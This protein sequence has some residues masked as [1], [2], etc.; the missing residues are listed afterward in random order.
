VA[1][2]KHLHG[3]L[4]ELLGEEATRFGFLW[5]RT[6]HLTVFHFPLKFEN[7]EL[8]CPQKAKHLIFSPG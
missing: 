2:Q 4:L 3:F 7:K 5:L 6:G 8:D 1:I